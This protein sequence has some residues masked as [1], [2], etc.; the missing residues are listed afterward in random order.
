MV[1][2][3]KN[4][5]VVVASSCRVFLHQHNFRDF[6]RTD[7][8]SNLAELAPHTSRCFAPV[9]CHGV[10][11]VVLASILL[12][13]V[14]HSPSSTSHVHVSTHVSSAAISQVRVVMMSSTSLPNICALCISTLCANHCSIG[15]AQVLMMI[16]IE[17]APDTT[18]VR[19]HVSWHRGH[20]PR[21]SQHW[22]T[23]SRRSRGRPERSGEC[24]RR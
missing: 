6:R 17:K 13:I 1:R 3:E 11:I 20:S 12:I 14:P 15:L 10:L 5:C 9:F 16:H 22:W 8:F 21:W 18:C 24:R 7:S 4:D 2:V 19:N 23:P